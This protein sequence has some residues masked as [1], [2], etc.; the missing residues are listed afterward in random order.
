MCPLQQLIHLLAKAMM[1]IQS[2][3]EKRLSRS[4]EWKSQGKKEEEHE[5]G[6]ECKIE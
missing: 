2:Y 5:D 1:P 4:Y 6:T 3:N